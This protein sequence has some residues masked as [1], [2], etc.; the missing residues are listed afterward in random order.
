M[1]LHF[2]IKKTFYFSF[3]FFIC[4]LCLS[5]TARRNEPSSE[6][7]KP[8]E[9]TTVL[10]IC[11]DTLKGVNAFQVF[12]LKEACVNTIL[13]FSIISFPIFG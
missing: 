1:K 5:D 13:I 7:Q 10:R 8:I 11:F 9:N 4:F 2:S 12:R 3:I 6:I